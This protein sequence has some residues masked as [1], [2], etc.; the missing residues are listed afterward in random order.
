MSNSFGILFDK[1]TKD[2]TSILEEI[3]NGFQH[4]VM[5]ISPAIFNNMII[6][7]SLEQQKHVIYYMYDDEDGVSL[8]FKA[9]SAHPIFEEDC[10][11][12]ALYEPP[13]QMFPGLTKDMLPSIGVVP[14][15]D[16]NFK[17]G[18]I[19][20]SNVDA[21]LSFNEMLSHLTKVTNKQD[22]Y[23]QYMENHK[24][25]KKERTFGEITSIAD[26]EKRCLDHE[27]GCAIGLIPA[28]DIIDYE[29]ANYEQHVDTLQQLDDYSKLMPV[30]YSWVNVTCHPEWLKFFDIDPFQVPSVAFYIPDKN[31]VGK[32]I[33]KFDL[34]T[35]QDHQ[36]KFVR[37]KL[38]T[39]APKSKPSQMVVEEHNCQAAIAEE[40]DS[41][42]GIGEMTDEDKALEEEILRE[43]MEEQAEREKKEAEESKRK[44]KSDKGKK[45]KGKKGK[46]GRKDEL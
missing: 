17:E 25:S 9:I 2:L 42:N 29:K 10:V 6:T 45:K 7:Y 27:K 11:F 32:L 8:N 40:Q 36:E 4:E 35:I 13:T 5:E 23:I 28:M 37:G 26:F 33:G 19:Q 1:N 34:E 16:P 39:W 24:R 14:R 44:K 21:R 30:Y 3:N 18:N 43:I 46:K 15:L 31:V 38:P 20:Q 41:S 22:D 12:M